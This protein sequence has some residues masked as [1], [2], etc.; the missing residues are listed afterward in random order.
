[1][2][3]CRNTD[4]IFVVGGINS[5]DFNHCQI[6]LDFLIFYQLFLILQLKW[7]VIISKNRMYK[8]LQKFLNNLMFSILGNQGLEKSQNYMEV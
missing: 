4:S 5:K 7:S 6:L 8:L 3:K 2:K 1:M